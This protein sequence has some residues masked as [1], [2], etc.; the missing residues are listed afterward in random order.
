MRLGLLIA[1]LLLARPG[2]AAT[3]FN[4]SSQYGVIP[5]A[6]TTN[7]PV[8]VAAWLYSVATNAT[9]WA[10]G[11]Q[12]SSNNNAGFIIGQSSTGFFTGRGGDTSSSTTVNS[13]TPAIPN[14]WM[15][16]ALV[17]STPS[18]RV[19][20]VN[21]MPENTN[22][23]SRN[24]AAANRVGA[25]ARTSLTLANYFNGRVAAAAVWNVALTAAEIA[26]LAGGGNSAAAVNPFRIRPESIVACPELEHDW[27]TAHS[28]NR[29]GTVMG[30]TNAPTP[31]AGPPLAP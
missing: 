25:G 5:E 1:A 19:I 20:Y 21:G 7:S 10:W 31:I 17:G 24:F 12:C 2:E 9:G 27:N 3:A 22:T 14:T 11:I 23:T 29:V 8:T 13:T 16:V 30:F 28:R 26:A 15:H 6:G 18:N 4:G